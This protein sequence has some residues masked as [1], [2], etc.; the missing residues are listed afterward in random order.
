V[1]GTVS[2]Q[3]DFAANIEDVIFIPTPHPVTDLRVADDGQVWFC[4][5]A[6]AQGY[7]GRVDTSLTLHTES[8]T[9]PG[10][11][12]AINLTSTGYSV[13]GKV[14]QTT[15]SEAFVRYEP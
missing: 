9:L 12:N 1:F 6:G 7:V 3:P 15:G 14:P 8:E 2:D 10:Q 5:P 13:V 11:A 4:G